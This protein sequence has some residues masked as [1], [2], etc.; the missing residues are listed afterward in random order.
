MLPV[1]RSLVLL[2]LVAACAGDGKQDPETKPDAAT[3]DASVIADAARDGGHAGDAATP[4]VQDG[5]VLDGFVV[6]PVATAMSAAHAVSADE[7]IWL[8]ARD[9]Q[10]VSLARASLPNGMRTQ[11]DAPRD[12]IALAVVGQQPYVLTTG[13]SIQAWEPAGPRMIATVLGFASRLVADGAV[14]YASTSQGNYSI[15]VLPQPGAPTLLLD[16]EAPVASGGSAYWLDGAH[17]VASRE[18][19]QRQL[20]AFA[21][22]RLTGVAE[23]SERTLFIADRKLYAATSGGA[24]T[25]LRQ[26]AGEGPLAVAS[27]V[28]YWLDAFDGHTVQRLDPTTGKGELI[29]RSAE[30][31]SPFLSP[32]KDGLI[33]GGATQLYWLHPR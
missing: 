11:I 25:E 10:V 24:A 18:G 7:L 29:W 19:V 32:W 30:P 33:V 4:E 21:G 27:G 9:R 23:L 12:T 31:L 26:L 17:L 28:V 2:S 15:R 22:T 20:V 5:G 8:E 14:L 6:E 1:R 3:S 16:V 13:G